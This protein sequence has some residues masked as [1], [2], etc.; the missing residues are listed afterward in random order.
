MVPWQQEWDTA[1]LRSGDNHGNLWIHFDDTKG[2]K[3]IFVCQCLSLPQG[4]STPPR[5]LRLQGAST[6]FV[7]H[8]IDVL[9]KKNLS[10]HV[11]CDVM[12]HETD[13]INCN[14]LPNLY[15]PT[16]FI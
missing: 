7:V 15:I 1:L 8:V 13:V 2:N 9:H 10:G 3:M 11:I 5:P 6:H 14:I 16:T 4:V 12:Q